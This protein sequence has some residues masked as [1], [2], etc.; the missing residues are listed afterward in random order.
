M[1]KMRGSAKIRRG[2]DQDGEGAMAARLSTVIRSFPPS[3]RRH[4]SSRAASCLA[5]D[6]FASCRLFLMAY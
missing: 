3:A 6:F 5:P 4:F 1:E 2:A